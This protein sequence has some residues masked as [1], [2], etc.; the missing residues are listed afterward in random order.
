MTPSVRYPAGPITPVGAYHF[1]H[2]RIPTVKLR[3]FDDTVVFAL[4]GGEAI[5]DRTIPERVELKDIK[6]LVPPW[7]IIDQKGATQ[8]G[9]TY[10]DTLYDPIEVEMDVV[11]VGRDPAWCR[12]VTNHLFGSLDSKRQSELSWFT[13]EMGRWWAPVRWFST[14][15]DSWKSG[16]RQEH[17][18]R[19]RA[20]T[21]FWQSYPHVDQFRFTYEAMT[22]TFETDHV[23]Q[24]GFSLGANWPQRYNGDGGG[25][26]YSQNAQARWLDDPDDTWATLSREVVNGPYKDFNTTSDNQVVNMVFGSFQE[27]AIFDGGFNDMWARMSRNS[28]GTWKGDG[29]RCRVGAL[30][31]RISYFVNYVEHVIQDYGILTP[32]TW[33]PPL[34]GEKYTLICGVNDGT[35]NKPRVY[36]V[37]RNGAPIGFPAEEVGTG[38]KVGAASRG[39]GF[40]MR[41]GAAL[42]TQATPANIRKISAGDNALAS[43][44]GFLSRVNAGDQDAWDRYTCF[45]PGTFRMYDGP[46]SEEYVEFG[47]LLPNQVA[48]VRT[49][50]RKYGVKDLTVTPTTPAQATGWE[51]AFADFTAFLSN[52]NADTLTN[53]FRSVIGIFD[54]SGVV[55]PQASL[56]SLLKG[57]FSTPIPP[58]SP[59]LPCKEYKVK[60]EIV[61]GNA[62]SMIIAALTPLRRYPY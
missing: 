16:R 42:L 22:E 18:L 6:G 25:Y 19:L 20:D 46:G 48:Q 34:P 21:G 23:G 52:A 17:S 45:G 1:L 7:Q 61:G 57:R 32:E 54:G 31:V 62:D 51:K 4:M 5:A 29:I 60:V 11:A 39:I 59:G 55:P 14:P 50:P 30:S 43:Q 58:K 37:L 10:V 8:D 49:D 56:Y 33:I 24:G 27:W 2:D 15:S 41:A 3:S 9:V 28:D 44:S 40:G 47:P 38:S 13:H 35:T 12:R 36:K 26:C 53:V